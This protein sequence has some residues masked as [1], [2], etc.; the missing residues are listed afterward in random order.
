MRPTYLVAYLLTCGSCLFMTGILAI[1]PIYF[2]FVI[3]LL[4]ALIFSEKG[5]SI[6]ITVGLYCFVFLMSFFLFAFHIIN[7]SKAIKEGLGFVFTFGYFLIGYIAARNCSKEELT[8]LTVML[9][10]LSILMGASDAVYRFLNPADYNFSELIPF[11]IFKENSLMFEDS[12]FTAFF[13]LTNY[14]LYTI[15]MWRNPKYSK[16]IVILFLL[17]IFA[18][19]SRA[20]GIGVV[21]FLALRYLIDSNYKAKILILCISIMILPPVLFY[22]LTN[23][24][25]LSDVALKL[26]VLQEASSNLFL[27]ADINT[28]FFGNGFASSSLNSGYSAHNFIIEVLYDVGFVGL[29][30]FSIPMLMLALLDKR[31]FVLFFIPIFVVSLSFGPLILPYT[32]LSLALLLSYSVACKGI[33]ICGP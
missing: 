12:N 8:N 15:V 32:Y 28:L 3:A 26:W 10:K 31:S 21:T 27:S 33:D 16:L 30:C 25:F 11:H 1:S 5:F 4:F 20:S 18:C 24:N 14:I 6:N 9:A 19:L 2:M 22:I 17:V 7:G 13:L 23:E 29:L